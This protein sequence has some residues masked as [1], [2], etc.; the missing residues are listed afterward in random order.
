MYKKAIGRVV[1]GFHGCDLTTK[2]AIIK[3]GKPFVMSKN[4]Y[5]WLG[6]GIYFWENDPQRAMEFAESVVKDHK[7]SKGTIQKPAVIGA[8]IDLGNCLDLSIRENIELLK[9]AN[10]TYLTIVGGEEK[11]L[12]NKGEL[13]D[14]KGRYRDCVV[15]NLLNKLTDLNERVTNF[16]TVRAMFFE[17]NKIYDTSAFS[18]Y[19]HIQICVRNPNCIKA[20]FEPRSVDEKY[21]IP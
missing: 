5:D 10:R 2:E 8:I 12:K 11:A 6:S 16:D 15:I 3:D 4:E 7:Q 18:E 14:M 13:P 9:A 1:Y 19:S 20:I 17:G 21:R